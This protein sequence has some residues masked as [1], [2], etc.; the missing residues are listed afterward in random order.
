[1]PK[2][3]QDGESVGYGVD[4]GPFDPFDEEVSRKRAM[5]YLD[6]IQKKNPDWSKEDVLR[7]YNWGPGNVHR[8]KS[9]SRKDIP[10]EAQEYP[11]KILRY[12]N[13]QRG[14]EAYFNR[15]GLAGATPPPLLGEEDMLLQ[16]LEAE[17][18]GA[19]PPLEVPDEEANVTF[20]GQDISA[21]ESVI[22][23]DFNKQKQFDAILSAVQNGQL[24]PDAAREAVKGMGSNWIGKFDSQARAGGVG[25]SEG[26]AGT[27][28][29]LSDN[30]ATDAREAL[31]VEDARQGFIDDWRKS[32]LV[33]RLFQQLMLL[34]ALP[35]WKQ[36]QS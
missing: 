34:L 15:G 35:L 7:A 36:I 13:E 29:E 5:Q 6:G 19:P 18:V 8:Y 27:V 16:E 1:M 9:G 28:G 2:F 26:L 25:E 11:H 24:K 4:S 33:R 22:Q 23:S 17:Q 10:K 30:L 12:L 14:N 21:E 32:L 3:W 31:G 20:G